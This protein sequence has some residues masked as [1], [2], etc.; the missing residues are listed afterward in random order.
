MLA[1]AHSFKDKS[2]R[3][4]DVN[5]GLFTYPVLMAADILLYDAEIVPVGKDQQQHLEMTRDIAGSFNHAYG[6][7]LVLPD[8]QIDKRVMTI[9]GTD[10]QKMSKSYNNF[11]DIFLP[12]KKLRKQ[13]MG[14]VTDSTP[15]EEPKDWSTCN[16]FKLYQ[17]LGSESQISDLKAQYEGGNFGYG[18][19][20]Q[21]LF[22]LI[23]EHFSNERERFDYLME[24]TGEI[25][26][27]LLKG[28]EKAR[29][30]AQSV[31]QRV[32]KKVGY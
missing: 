1:N 11:I 21:A 10:G 26:A 31:L 24:N 28:A 23:L 12:E 25:E 2:N 30:I 4:S 15:L 9:P 20:K 16:V 7:T 27:E 3:L 8:A 29:V 32:R 17:L 19:A 14:I 18:H 6:D 5:S 22:E 13:I